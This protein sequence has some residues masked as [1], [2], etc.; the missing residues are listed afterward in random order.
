MNK[1]AHLLSFCVNHVTECE[2]NKLWDLE[3]IGVTPDELYFSSVPDY[4][5]EKFNKTVS[6][7]NGRYEVTLPWKSDIAKS[8]LQDNER[9]AH[10][11]LLS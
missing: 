1:V 11:R 10:K 3:G 5:Q 8:D 4:V 9:L 7:V 6:F 2:V